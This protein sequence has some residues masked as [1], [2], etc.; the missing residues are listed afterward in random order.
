MRSGRN[1]K[2]VK[3]VDRT[4]NELVM[5]SCGLTRG[6]LIFKFDCQLSSIVNSRQVE[7]IG[8]FTT[9]GALFEKHTSLCKTT[10][11]LKASLTVT[12]SIH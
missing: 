4:L 12:Y 7:S 9:G 6:A 2:G 1:G 11:R 10:F 5:S 8:R 3:Q